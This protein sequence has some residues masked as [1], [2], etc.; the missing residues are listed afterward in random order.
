GPRGDRTAADFRLT[1]AGDLI[2]GT[3]S[4]SL[5]SIGGFA[6]ASESV[7]HF[8]KHNSR[9]LIFTAA[10]PPANTA[11]VLMALHILQ[12]EP[13]RRECLW[14]NTRRLPCGLPGVGFDIDPT[15]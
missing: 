5:A 8:L 13:E 10:L 3:F 9:P 11:G 7:I 15:E 6:A 2:V 4:K 12:R 1:D 14:Q